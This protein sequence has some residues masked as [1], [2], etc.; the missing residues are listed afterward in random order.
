MFWRYIFSYNGSELSLPKIENLHMSAHI[1]Y[2]RSRSCLLMVWSS[3]HICFYWL[4][5]FKFWYQ[6]SEFILIFFF[7][8]HYNFKSNCRENIVDILQN[9]NCL[10]YKNYGEKIFFFLQGNGNSLYFFF[11]IVFIIFIIHIHQ[12]TL[13]TNKKYWYQTRF[14]NA[15]LQSLNWY[16]YFIK[17]IYNMIYT[18]LI[19]YIYFWDANSW[20]L[21]S[22]SS[23]F[24]FDR[25]M[26]RSTPYSTKSTLFIEKRLMRVKRALTLWK[27][28]RVVK[29]QCFYLP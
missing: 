22:I 12:H 1:V 16:N 6:I 8:L 21:P 24:R 7:F 23:D 13:Y 17:T 28:K 4:C 18:W 19:K 5:L 9:I 2:K 15:N 20:T 29:W 3:R 11:I 27:S 14:D 10:M 26:Q 25:G